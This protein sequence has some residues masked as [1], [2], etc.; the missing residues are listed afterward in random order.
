MT[1]LRVVIA[2]SET[3]IAKNA[4]EILKIL[5]CVV[6]GRACD[7]YAAIKVI[8][9]T[10][11]EFVILGGELSF[12][13]VAK[14]VDENWLAPLLLLT[15]RD[16]WACIGSEIEK[17]EFDWLEKPVKPEILNLKM[18]VGIEKFRKNRDFALETEKIRSEKTTRNL[19]NK[20][21]DIL[22]RNMGISEI[23]AILKIQMMGRKVE[24]PMRD[25]AHMIISEHRH[26]S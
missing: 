7:E 11:P 12:L 20:A 21:K 26:V 5:G 8:R 16:S 4:E 10:Q 19:V 14:T 17:W 2:I 3:R 6:V 18:T 1:G 9:A 15:D 13:D 22:V 25:I 24:L 23:Q